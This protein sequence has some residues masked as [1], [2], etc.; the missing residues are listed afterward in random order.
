MAA[1]GR[2]GTLSEVAVVMLTE[3]LMPVSIFSARSRVTVTV[4]LVLPPEFTP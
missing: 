3:A 2:V 4:Y 1:A